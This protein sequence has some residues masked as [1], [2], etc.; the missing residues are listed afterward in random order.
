MADDT[1]LIFSADNGGVYHGGQR[2]NNF[3]LRGQKTS[4]WEGG[5]RATAFLWGGANVLPAAVRG[6]TSNAFMHI[7]DWYKTLSTLVGVDAADDARGVPPIDSIDVWAAL[8]RPNATAADSLR[9]EVP[10]AFCPNTDPELGMRGPDNC[11]PT[12]GIL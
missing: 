3:P 5:V 7:C 1:L 12:V 8:M 4:S 6:T 9:R 2:G 11:C 10:L